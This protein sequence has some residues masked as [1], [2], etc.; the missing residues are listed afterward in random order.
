MKNC[1][2]CN[3]QIEDIKKFCEDCGTKQ[4]EISTNNNRDGKYNAAIG[5]K[6]VISGNI[7]GKNEEIKVAGNATF[8]RIEDDTKKIIICAVSGKHLLRGRDFVVNCPKCKTDV[9]QEYFNI[10]ASRCFNCDNYAIE[11][12]NEKLEIILSDGIIDPIERIKLDSFAISLM[13]GDDTKEKIEF[14]A[15]NRKLASQVND[16]GSKLNELSIFEKIQYKK[17]LALVFEKSDFDKALEILYKI[18][19]D[20]VINE[21]VAFNYYLLKAIHKPHDYITDYNNSSQRN[22]DYYWENF[23]AFLPNLKLDNLEF[24][25]KIIILNKA[26]FYDKKN[27][28]FLFV[29]IYN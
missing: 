29:F 3:L 21:D 11:Q 10:I 5:D 27:D 17:S 28:N 2:Q 15:K 16:I 1:I 9:S 26:R 20:N 25:N 14:A 12:Y 8:N 6:N 18:H 24:C 19:I 13:I 7:I 22:T 4:P 23:W